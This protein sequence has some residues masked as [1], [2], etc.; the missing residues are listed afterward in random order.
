MIDGRGRLVEHDDPAPPEQP[1]CGRCGRFL[2]W[3][4]TERE[5]WEGEPGK[6]YRVRG[7]V[8]DCL[9]CRWFSVVWSE[10]RR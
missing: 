5:W 2:P 4:P 8:L 10:V 3:K 6:E 1:R 9:G 7:E